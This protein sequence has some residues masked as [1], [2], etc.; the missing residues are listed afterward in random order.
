MKAMTMP[1][2]SQYIITALLLI[3]AATLLYSISFYSN[4][5]NQH[6]FYG[7]EINTPAPQFKLVN[8]NGKN[9]D[10]RMF[11]G[12]YTYL[13]FG[14]LNCTKTCHTQ[15]LVLDALSKQLAH[16]NMVQYAY[17]SMDPKRDDSKRLQYYFKNKT[18]SLSILKGNNIK[19]IQ[20]I[21]N[22]FNAP[23]SIQKETDINYEI[24]HPAYLY[25]INPEGNLSLIYTGSVIDT[26][27]IKK[28][29]NIYKLKFS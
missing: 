3:S 6:Q 23:Y 28:D 17:I 7:R 4:P 29:L 15:A 8:L 22:Q 26:H 10:N 5:F 27:A 16:D 25:L 24:K 14:Y 1:N 13:M 9:I 11:K 12:R 19:E 20:A 18:Q 21:A 2:I